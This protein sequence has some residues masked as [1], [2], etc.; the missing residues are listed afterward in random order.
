MT[1]NTVDCSEDAGNL[2]AD[3]PRNVL[4]DEVF[5]HLLSRPGMRIERI[6]STGQSSADDDWYDQDTDEWV[7]LLSGEAGLRIES[8]TSDRHLRPGDW[9][10]LPAH[11]RHRVTWTQAQPATVWLAVH[12]SPAGSVLA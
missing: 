4:P 11:R 3:L 10:Y 2:F 12:L 1:E 5:Q 9:L 6:I 7:V 8:E